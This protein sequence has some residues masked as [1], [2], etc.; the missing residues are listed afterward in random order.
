MKR[1][2]APGLDGLPVNFYNTFWLLFE[3]YFVGVFNKAF[4]TGELAESQKN[5]FYYLRL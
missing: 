3:N 4:E 5:D 2:K 1:S